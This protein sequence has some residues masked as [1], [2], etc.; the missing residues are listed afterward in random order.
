VDHSTKLLVIAKR[1]APQFAMLAD[2]PHVLTCDTAAAAAAM[3]NVEVILQWSGTR[4]MLREAFAECPSLRWIHS[5]FVGVDSYLFPEL[6]KSDVVLTN[7]KGVYSASLG[8]FVLTAI[9][10]FAKDIPRLQRNQAAGAWA[11]FEMEMIA[12]RTVGIVGYGD[13]GGA[14]AERAHALGMRIVATKRHAPSGPDPLIERYYRP[15][16]LHAMLAV[17]DYVV[18]AA[19]L[20]PETRQMVGGAEFAAMKP[21]A[22]LINVGRGP[23][24]DTDALMR[25]LNNGRIK[26]AGLDV[27]DPEPL[28]AGHA[29]YG[30]ENVLLSPHCAD[31]IAGWK[32]DSMRF[33]LEQYARFQ[34]SEPL[35]NVVD[36]R[37]GY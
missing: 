30:M 10:Y 11:P 19:P 23:V 21:T 35:L 24:V 22:V 27:V 1:E 12:G 25:A 8:E 28:P 16:E 17:C 29:L 5:R 9:L 3:Q 18:V 32:D 36:K 33:F 34:K 13:I 37:L 26:G 4:E 31:Q 2:V 7:A 15:A 20:T 14:V 6:V